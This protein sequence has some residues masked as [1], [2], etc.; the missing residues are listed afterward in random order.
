MLRIVPSFSMQLNYLDR[1]REAAGDRPGIS[2]WD[3]T[4]EILQCQQ[5]EYLMYTQ[6]GAIET[7]SEMTVKVVKVLLQKRSRDIKL[8]RA[9]IPKLQPKAINKSSQKKIV[10]NMLSHC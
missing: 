4:V 9:G 7:S 8:K 3:L 6:E 2:N 10:A 5:H 1:D